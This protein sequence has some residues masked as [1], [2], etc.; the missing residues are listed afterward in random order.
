MLEAKKKKKTYEY[1]RFLRCFWH[2]QGLQRLVPLLL[3]L[4]LATAI[5]LL[6]LFLL[7]KPSVKV[8]VETAFLWPS[9][10]NTGSF[11][12]FGL[13]SVSEARTVQSA[14]FCE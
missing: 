5:A 9:K 8:W 1:E 3:L 13:H 12:S 10:A 7:E 6:L 4:L 14:D 11:S 2:Q